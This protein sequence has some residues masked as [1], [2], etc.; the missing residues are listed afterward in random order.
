M[1]DDHRFIHAP[2][3]QVG[4]NRHTDRPSCYRAIDDGRACACCATPELQQDLLA[5]TPGCEL[6]ARG[7]RAAMLYWRYAR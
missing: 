6:C 7:Q 2:Q 5:H 3:F 1:K 4:M